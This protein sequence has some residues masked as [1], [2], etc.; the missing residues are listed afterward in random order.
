V[1]TWATS[2]VFGIFLVLG[3]ALNL[4]ADA[5]HRQASG[6][7]TTAVTATQQPQQ[8]SPASPVP[9]VPPAVPEPGVRNPEVPPAARGAAPEQATPGPTNITPAG[10]PSTQPS[11]PQ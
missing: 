6:V 9:T 1:L 3:I 5:H 7:G 10:T 4:L 2:I 11:G 8:S